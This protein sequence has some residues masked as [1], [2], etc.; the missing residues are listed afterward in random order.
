MAV[1]GQNGS[2]PF[3]NKT[4]RNSI[5]KYIPSPANGFGMPNILLCGLACTLSHHACGKI[6]QIW[7]VS[8]T[9]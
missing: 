7:G 6:P 9:M 8:F 5:T 2:N 1:I 4:V 3:I